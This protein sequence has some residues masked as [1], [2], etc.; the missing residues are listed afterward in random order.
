[1]ASGNV[2]ASY[3]L[4]VMLVL[5]LGMGQLAHGVPIR[6]VPCSAKVRSALYAA[7]VPATINSDHTFYLDAMHRSK[8][9]VI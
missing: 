8:Q 5:A 1:M 6:M 9:V 3:L 4:P 7:T 2:A